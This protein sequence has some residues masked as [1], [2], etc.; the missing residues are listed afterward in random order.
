MESLWFKGIPLATVLAAYFD[1]L[2][3]NYIFNVMVAD[4]IYQDGPRLFLCLTRGRH[5]S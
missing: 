4:Y 3:I 5:I 1:D 2:F